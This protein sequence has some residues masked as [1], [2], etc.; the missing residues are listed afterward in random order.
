MVVENNPTKQVSNNTIQA[1]WVALGSLSS[2]ALGITTAAILSRYL[3]KSEYGTYKQIIYVYSTLLVVFSAGIPR[4][5]AYFLPRYSLA[6]GKSIVKKVNRVLTLAGIVFSISLYLL[7]DLIS[8]ILKNSELSNGLKVFSVIPMLLVPTLGIEGIFSTYKKTIFIAIYNTLT[9]VI[10][11]FCII[12]PVIFFE[13]GYISAIYGWVF[14]SSLT[15]IAAYFFKSYPF[16]NVKSVKTS[17]NYK[18]VFSYSLPLVGASLW[19]I[20][21]KSADQFFISRYFGSDVFAEYSNGFIELPFVAMITASASVVLMPIFSKI[22]HQNRDF[23]ELLD[24]WLRTMRKSSTMIY[25][26]LVYCMAFATEIIIILYSEE[27]V[28]SASY[29]RINMV[30]NFFNIIIFAPLFLSSGN[31]KLY[32]KVHAFI[33]FGVWITNYIIVQNFDSP[34]YI[35]FS[36]VFYGVFKILIFM[37][38]TSILLKTSFSNLFPFKAFFKILIHCLIAVILVKILQFFVLESFSLIIQLLFTFLIYGV[39]LTISGKWIGI[40]YDEILIPIFQKFKNKYI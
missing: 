25:P 22:F 9:R 33:A 14:S 30:L 28:K 26:L 18:Q 20:A 37:Y 29:F 2:I 8:E 6:E 16:R 1:F 23:S 19:G 10:M 39:L 5:F 15:F 31:T 3:D 11:L 36:S 24:I 27:Y 32:A 34:I 35:A 13:G 21:I 38:L 7:S 12:I 4:V 40:H 17:L